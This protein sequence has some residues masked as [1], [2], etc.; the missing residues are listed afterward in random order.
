MARRPRNILRQAQ[1]GDVFRCDADRTTDFRPKFSCE[2]STY[3]CSSITDANL[4]LARMRAASNS[5]V[6][7][8]DTI[9]VG[10]ETEA[11][12][13]WLPTAT[14]YVPLLPTRY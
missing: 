3:R 4:N 2:R 9:Q 6:V 14:V 13:P 10:T 1:T 8:F 5:D 7:M 11:V 12:L